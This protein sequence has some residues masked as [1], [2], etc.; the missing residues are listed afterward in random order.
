MQ[1]TFLIL[2]SFIL[3]SQPLKLGWK[4]LKG[5]GVRVPLSDGSHAPR[6]EV[7]ERRKL[8]FLHQDLAR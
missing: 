3:N 4:A 7:G 2:R 1:K 6:E 5:Q 8:S